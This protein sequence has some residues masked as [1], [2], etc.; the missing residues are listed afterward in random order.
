[1]EI[2]ECIIPTKNKPMIYELKIGRI[3]ISI[4]R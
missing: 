2:I 4:T 1:M 3:G